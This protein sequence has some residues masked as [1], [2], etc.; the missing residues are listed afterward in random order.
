MHGQVRRLSELDPTLPPGLVDVVHRAIEPDRVRRWSTAVELRRALVP[1][2]GRLSAAGRAAAV[3]TASGTQRTED[4]VAPLGTVA[5]PIRSVHGVAPT[6]PPDQTAPDAPPLAGAKGSTQDVPEH[7]LQE[8]ATSLQVAVPAPRVGF[9]TPSASYQTPGVYAPPPPRPARRRHAVGAVVALLLG[10]LV[11]GGGIAAVVL[12]RGQQDDGE[13]S[14]GVPSSLPPATT[15]AAQSP[16]PD[17]GAAPP[18]ATPPT[19]TAAK[20]GKVAPKD[21]GPDAPADG[22]LFQL[23]FPFPSVFPPFPSGLPPLLPS[24]WPPVFPPSNVQDQPERAP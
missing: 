24:A 4:E 15:I 18:T 16:G 13:S 23:P 14:F 19:V 6:L 20:G 9:T 1:F 12:L 17:S 10:L 8:I 7:V 22:G 21:A 11:T 2:A 3:S 5:E